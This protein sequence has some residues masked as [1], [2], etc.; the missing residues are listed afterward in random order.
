MYF[1]QGDR[2]TGRGI[3]LVDGG[4][5]AAAGIGNCVVEVAVA[6]DRL[7]HINHPIRDGV[8]GGVYL[9]NSRVVA[10]ISLDLQ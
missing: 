8:L 3:V 4:C 9:W 7:H 5:I 6:A 2:L 10:L 1:R